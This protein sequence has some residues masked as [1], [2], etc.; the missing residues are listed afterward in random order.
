MNYVWM[1]HGEAY[2]DLCRQSQETVRKHDPSAAFTVYVDKGY[3]IEGEII[4]PGYHDKPFM[5]MNVVCQAHWLSMRPA[6]GEVVCFLD[7]DA[8]MNKPLPDLGNDW[9]VAPTWRENMGHLSQ[10][11]PYNYG[12]VFARQTVVAQAAWWWMAQH[13]YYQTPKHQKWYANQIAL[14]ELCG[15]PADD[16]SVR[17]HEYF[18]VTVKPLP[19]DIWNY[20]PE[21][22]EDV[23]DKY[24][25]H[26]K[27]NRKDLL[28]YYHTEIMEAA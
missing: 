19:G 28:A 12:V 17:E 15:P 13:I 3:G 20:T 26:C 21:G 10:Q 16:I 11:M 24:F 18:N 27:G 25:V 6:T 2:V 14:R 23:S 8:F 7:V 4:I 9:D 1:A 5:M 22:E